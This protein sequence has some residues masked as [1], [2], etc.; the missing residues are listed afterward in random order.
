M[1]A[2]LVPGSDERVIIICSSPENNSR[3]HNSDED[4]AI[5]N[6]QDT[7]E[8]HCASQDALMKVHERILDED[9]FGGMTSDYN[10]ELYCHSTTFSS[11]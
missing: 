7:I 3:N 5:E 11:K 6:E 8:P 10:N 2:D 1:V 4:S 9:F